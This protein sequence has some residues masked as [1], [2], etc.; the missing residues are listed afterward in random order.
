MNFWRICRQNV[1]KVCKMTTHESILLDTDAVSVLL[2]GD[3]RA[4]QLLPRLRDKRRMLSFMSVAELFQWA[5]MRHWG[6]QRKDELAY[7]IKTQYIILDFKLGLAQK[8]AQVRAEAKANGRPISVQDGWIAA[9]SL[10]FDVP[11][12]TLNRK[13]FEHVKNI[14]MLDVS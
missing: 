7:V 6:E 3:T 5:E 14:K 13:D 1:S 11:L 4:V 2:K 10:Y 8:W 9:T 12:L